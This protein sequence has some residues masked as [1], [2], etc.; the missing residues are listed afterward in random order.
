MGA[1]QMCRLHGWAVL[2]EFGLPDRRRADIMALTPQG[3][4]VCIEIKSG[5]PDFRADHKW[6]DYLPWCD[7]LY[8]AVN[9]DF[10]HT[11][12]PDT[13]GLIVAATGR[14]PMTGRPAWTA[15]SSA[16]RP[17]SHWPR[18]AGAA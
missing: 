15:H 13:A 5:L 4:L 10:P 2:H 3:H 17:T 1:S 6:P 7:Q 12:L 14:A 8:F 9:Q 16:P 18:H 11:V